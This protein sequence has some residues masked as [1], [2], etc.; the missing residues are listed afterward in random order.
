MIDI[1]KLKQFVR[2]KI[3]HKYS[4]HKED[5]FVLEYFKNKRNGFYVDVGCYD[6][7]LLS[8]T[9][10]LYKNGWHGI[11]IDPIREKIDVFDR[12]RKRDTNLCLAI[13]NEETISFFVGTR[14]HDA[15]DA[16]SSESE[17]WIKKLKVPYEKRTVQ[18]QTLVSIFDKHLYKDIDFL[19]VDTEGFD[20]QVLKTNNWEKYR[21]RLIL[22]E[23][24][25]DRKNTIK[26]YL[27]SIGYR[28]IYRNESNSFFED[29]K[30]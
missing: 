8:N 18:K 12:V 26:H 14:S 15:N 16:C 3:L 10:L 13:G 19:D 25:Y 24:N 11:N 30:K 27:K 28:Q 6:P 22:V 23:T 29:V 17:E 9:A 4:E 1:I 20:L 2:H 7:E 21:P 5:K